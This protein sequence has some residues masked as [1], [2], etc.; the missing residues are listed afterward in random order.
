MHLGSIAL[1]LAAGLVMG[2]LV[3]S[4]S[5]PAEAQTT[6]ASTESTAVITHTLSY[7]S[8]VTPNAD[9]D[10]L[11]ELY[12]FPGGAPVFLFRTKAGLT[13][14]ERRDNRLVKL[15]DI[16]LDSNFEKIVFLEDGQTF[17]V[18][19]KN[20]ARVYAIKRT[21]TFPENTK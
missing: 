5:G 11:Q 13:A 21:V 3:A 9:T 8:Q 6:T 17:I 7:I 12:V 18:Q 14:W 16:N 10:K 19:Y 4:G 2:M 20:A 1:A 15:L